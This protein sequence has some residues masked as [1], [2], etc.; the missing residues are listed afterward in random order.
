MGRTM[1]SAAISFMQE[2]KAFVKFKRALSKQDQLRVEE[3]FVYA[4]KHMAVI[5]YAAHILPFE[6]IMLAMLLEEHKEVMKLREIV[7]DLYTAK[8]RG[9]KNT[10]RGIVDLG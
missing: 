6:T 1:P 10:G 4:R 2:Q 9:E 7:D 8:N 3:L 5:Q